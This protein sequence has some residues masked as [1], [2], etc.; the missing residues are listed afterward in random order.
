[1]HALRDQLSQRKRA[2]TSGAFSSS[3]SRV[4]HQIARRFVCRDDARSISRH[5]EFSG[6]RPALSREKIYRIRNRRDLSRGSEVPPWVAHASRALAKISRL[7][8]LVFA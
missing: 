7:R 5:R 3:T 1:F 2:A 4:V 6:R 8:A